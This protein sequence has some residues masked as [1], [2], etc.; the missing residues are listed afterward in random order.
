[1]W[2]HNGRMKSGLG[3]GFRSV[4]CLRLPRRRR[5]PTV[6]EITLRQARLAGRVA[7]DIGANLGIFSLFFSRAV[8]AQGQVV[9]FEPMPD[10]FAALE[11]NLK[12]N[13]VRNV[14][15][16]QMALG[17]AA[18]ERAAYSVAGESGR[19]SIEVSGG[20]DERY[21]PAGVC[22]IDTLDQVVGRM[23]L[24]PPGFIKIDVEGAELAVLRGAAETLRAT[25]PEMFIELHG[26]GPDGK[27]MGAERL[28]LELRQLG[29]AAFHM[30]TGARVTA[31]GFVPGSGHW[32]C[33]PAHGSRNAFPPVGS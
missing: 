5:A 19:Y 16:I 3:A 6:E 13:R 31:G 15:A 30:E 7:Y 4:E 11:R 29:Y 25:W 2:P 14:T 20:G 27:A 12:L 9:A 22:R 26:T 24:P 23:N 32:C 1:M 18:G 8:G 21:T 10:N 17:E 28:A 33:V